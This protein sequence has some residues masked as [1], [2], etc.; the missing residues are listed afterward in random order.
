[1]PDTP[2]PERHPAD[3]PYHRR[4]PIGQRLDAS[5][6][7]GGPVPSIESM[8][9]LPLDEMLVPE[10]PRRGE[11][12][13]GECGTCRVTEH[14]LWADEDWQV[15][16]GFDETGLPFIGAIAPRAHVL[17]EDAPVELLAGLG[18]LMQR[19]SEAV[20]L[21]PGVARC[22]FG[23]WNDG[24]AH[25]H[26]WALARPAGMM[27]GRGAMLAFWDEVLPPLEPELAETNNRIV[28]EALAAGGGRAFPA[29]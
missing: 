15:K 28:A 12:D 23:R 13:P 25:L 24:S 17:L 10:L 8:T 3:S 4:L 11:L 21:V 2:A 18:P 27:Q 5:A 22:H 26:L 7:D 1:M 9:M 16:S 19:I 20:K 29:R 6:V 14:T